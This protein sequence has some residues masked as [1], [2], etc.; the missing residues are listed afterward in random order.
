MLGDTKACGITYK[1]TEVRRGTGKR[2]LRAFDVAE[3][4]VAKCIKTRSNLLALAHELKL[5]GKTDLAEFVINRSNK[6]V[7]THIT[8]AWEV[9]NAI[10]ETK[11]FKTSRLDLLR[12]VG[13]EKCICNI[14][15]EWLKSTISLLEKNNINPDHFS[16]CVRL[17]LERGR[18]K[19]RNIMPT[20]LANC[21]KTFLLNTLNIVVQVLLGS[22]LRRLKSYFLMIFAGHNELLLGMTSC[23]FL[24]GNWYISLNPNHT[25]P[26][27]LSLTW[28][29]QSSAQPSTR[30]CL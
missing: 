27:I 4:C 2:R 20:G 12:K 7:N 6:I 13:N 22:A 1:E 10:E 3:I 26:R 19:Y 21:G 8:T 17:L 5:E 29:P 18:G 23:S 30:S 28:I 9:E 16:Q 15:N 24:R 25:M 14:E 11:R